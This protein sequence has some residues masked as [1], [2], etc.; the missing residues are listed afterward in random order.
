MNEKLHFMCLLK[1]RFKDNVRNA[2][3]VG[4]SKFRSLY[5]DDFFKKTRVV[6]KKG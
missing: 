3:W 5:T 6:D 1:K 4:H 2:Y